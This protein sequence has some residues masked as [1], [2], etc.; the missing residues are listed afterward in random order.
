MTTYSGRICLNGY[1]RKNKTDDSNNGVP[2]A[3]NFFIV[4]HKASMD[5]LVIRE[6]RAEETEDIMSIPDFNNFS[7]C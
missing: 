5:I 2:P 7:S 3:R 1:D 4:C 6:T